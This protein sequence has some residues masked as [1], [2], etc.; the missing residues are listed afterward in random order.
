MEQ[1]GVPS[2]DGLRNGDATAPR[3]GDESRA[4]YIGGANRTDGADDGR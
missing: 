4:R 2:C 1:S 3:G